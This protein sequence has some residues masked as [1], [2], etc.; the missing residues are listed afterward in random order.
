MWTCGQFMANEN[1]SGTISGPLRWGIKHLM[2][3]V[4]HFWYETTFNNADPNSDIS[5]K[6]IN[7]FSSY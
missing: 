7:P 5:H 4:L 6:L 3:S 1:V 2:E